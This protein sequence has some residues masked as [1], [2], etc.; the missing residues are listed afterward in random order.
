MSLAV[1]ST[2]FDRTGP[3]Y[4]NRE[5][6][7]LAIDGENLTV[8]YLDNRQEVTHSN[9]TSRN[10]LNDT[11]ER[12]TKL[13]DQQ[14]RRGYLGEEKLTWDADGA[15]AWSLGW[16]AGDGNVQFYL[17]M[18]DDK[19]TPVSNKYY[20]IT[21]DIIAVKPG[22][23]VIAPAGQKWGF[24]AEI[25]FNPTNNLPDQ[26]ASKQTTE[27]RIRGGVGKEDEGSI[28]WA[29][30]RLGFRLD[31][32]QDVD[33]IRKNIPA[34]QRVNFDA[35]VNGQEPAAAALLGTNL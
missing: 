4:S 25:R 13:K 10:K 27:G 17:H 15:L 34:T 11:I 2:G 18:S 31:S 32:P 8:R 23:I 28:F 1:G 20:S 3:N 24:Q 33:A 16:F 5:Y 6:E 14:D 22:K 26:L 7:V 12:E 19:F 30:V 29:L 21:G 35:G 9:F